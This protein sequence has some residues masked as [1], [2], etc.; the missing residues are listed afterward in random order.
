M[1]TFYIR[2]RRSGAIVNAVTTSERMA[3]ISLDRFVDSEHLFLDP[4]PPASILHAYRYWSER[5]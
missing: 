4:N 5:P 2:D 3:D 1:T